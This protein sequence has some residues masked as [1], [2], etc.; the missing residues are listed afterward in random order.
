MRK[1]CIIYSL[2]YIPGPPRSTILPPPWES[3]SRVSSGSVN[4]SVVWVGAGTDNVARN[5]PSEKTPLL[6]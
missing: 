6:K 3:D 5:G 1:G 4:G 2:N